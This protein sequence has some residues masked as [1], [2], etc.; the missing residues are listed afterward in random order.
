[1]KPASIPPNRFEKHDPEKSL[2]FV[3]I[4]VARLLRRRFN[5]R[6]ESLGLTPAQSQ[7]LAHLVKREGIKQGALAQIMEI[8]PITLCRLID[9]L[10]AAGWVERRPDP[11]DRR[12]VRLFM[13]E[14]AGPI[15]EF[16]WKQA[17]KT[18]EEA[19]QDLSDENRDVLLKTLQTVRINLLAAETETETEIELPPA[20]PKT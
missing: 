16:M 5:R 2:G 20:Q 7:A 6:I 8:Q 17:A 1:M 14:E 13:T 3:M 19:L 4:D 10:A 18:R 9:K 12:T 11:D 15:V